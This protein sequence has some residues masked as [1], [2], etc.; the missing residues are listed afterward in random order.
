VVRTG[1]GL[2]HQS[3]RPY[4]VLVEDGETELHR[5][6]RSTHWVLG[7]ERLFGHSATLPV[8]A[9]RIELYHRDIDRPR[10]R[11]ENLFETLGFFPE[12]EEDRIR[13]APERARSSGVEV[14]VRGSAGSSVDWWMSY[15]LSRARDRVDGREVRRQ[16]DQPHALDLA[17][18]FRLPRNWALTLTWRYHTGWPTTPV[19]IAVV[20]EDESGEEVLLPQVG[21][22][23]SERLPSYHRMDLRASRRFERARGQLHLYVDVH[24]LYDRRNVAGYDFEVDEESGELI[25]DED[26]WVGI[27]PSA[28]ITWEF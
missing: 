15:S 1:W 27:L 4:E 9:L 6:E 19:T 2:F 11:Y 25:V 18:H 12:V 10:P 16:L 5:A 8:E 14:L 3:Q 22:R 23:N 13:V 24:N 20:A 28:G 21:A 26:G 17:T 7:Y